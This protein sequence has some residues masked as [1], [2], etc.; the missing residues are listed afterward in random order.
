MNA[1]YYVYGSIRGG[2]VRTFA[3]LPTWK[4]A[5]SHLDILLLKMSE[6]WELWVSRRPSFAWTHSHGG[7]TPVN[8]VTANTQATDEA[9]DY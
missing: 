1:P 6:E 7:R 8:P 5:Q 9:N 3:E 2:M 4:E